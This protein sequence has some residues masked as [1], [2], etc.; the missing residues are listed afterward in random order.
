MR[1][2]IMATGYMPDIDKFSPEKFDFLCCLEDG[3]WCLGDFDIC[4]R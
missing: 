1:C 2:L 3:N 4:I